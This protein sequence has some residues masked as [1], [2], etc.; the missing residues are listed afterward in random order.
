MQLQVSVFVYVKSPFLIVQSWVAIALLPDRSAKM[1]SNASDSR[2]ACTSRRH[3][4][5][6]AARV[7]GDVDLL[8]AP[9]WKYDVTTGPDV[10]LSM[11]G[12]SDHRTSHAPPELLIQPTRPMTR[13]VPQPPLTVN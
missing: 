10:G 2:S 4:R 8:A 13:E 3:T 7:H 11:C 5:D 12:T 1:H 6:A 9:G